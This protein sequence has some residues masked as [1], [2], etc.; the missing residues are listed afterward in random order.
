VEEIK[1][2]SENSTHPRPTSQK[3]FLKTGGYI[4][5]MPLRKRVELIRWIDVS[6]VCQL[7]IPVGH[8]RLTD[9]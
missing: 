6:F 5:W 9:R 7:E 1:G 4:T 3:D 2:T 8:R